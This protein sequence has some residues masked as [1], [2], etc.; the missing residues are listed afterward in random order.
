MT[1]ERRFNLGFLGDSKRKTRKVWGSKYRKFNLLVLIAA[2]TP[3]AAVGLFNVALDP[4]GV[5]DSPKIAGINQSKPR[6]GN[7]DRLFK[8]TDIIRIKPATL[9]FGSSRT[10]QGL[11]PN[12]AAL[13]DKQPAYNLGLNGANPYEQ[14]R[15]LEHAIA[16]N[17]N[18]KTVIIGID[19]FMFNAY[20]E[21][22]PGFTEDRLEKQSISL[23]DTMNVVFSIDALF[24]S[25]E[26]LDSS[27]NTQN[28]EGDSVK[29]FMPYKN[30]DLGKKVTD[31]RFV[32]SYK[33][34]FKNHAKYQLSEKY[35]AD[36]KTFVETC[37]K[38]GITLKVYISPGHATDNEAIRATGHWSTQEKWKREIVKIVPVWDFYGY[39]SITSE[40]IKAGMKNYADS[41]HYRENIGNLILNRVL[42]YQSNTVPKDFGVLIT[43]ENLESHLAKINVNRENWVVKNQKEA[44]LVE[45]IK[46]D[47][48]RII[49]AENK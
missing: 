3:M 17:K 4:Y 7:N 37:K 49:A 30:I 44:K 39:N 15:Y 36:F 35:L 34:Y 25:L 20:N 41:S 43:P 46:R 22:Q 31:W 1:T 16:N 8:A 32:N 12:Y 23:P 42:N 11:D 48:D 10:R 38:H 26:T 2:F 14:L 19:F 18:L 45:N 29:G 27:K 24:S 13:K 5:F 33:V 9:L 6:K 28:K 40:P 47:Y 21:N